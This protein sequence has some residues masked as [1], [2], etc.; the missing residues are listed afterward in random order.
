MRIRRIEVALVFFADEKFTD[1]RLSNGI[2]ILVCETMGDHLT[3]GCF[4]KIISFTTP[5]TINIFHIP[6][7]LGVVGRVNFF[8]FSQTR[9]YSSRKIVSHI[10]NSIKYLRGDFSVGE[11]KWL[12]V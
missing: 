10:R 8:R 2:K 7:D 4:A 11:R 5:I 3:Y 6:K 9:S 12:W 1:K